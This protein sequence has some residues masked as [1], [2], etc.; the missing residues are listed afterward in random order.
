[1]MY[2]SVAS[3]RQMLEI[4]AKDALQRKRP[5][6]IVRK[7]TMPSAEIGSKCCFALLVFF[8]CLSS[9]HNFGLAPIAFRYHERKRQSYRMY[10]VDELYNAVIYRLAQRDC[11]LSQFPK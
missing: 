5:L 4:G 7:D 11:S 8:L 10:S 3:D 2:L 6:T 9:P 1:M